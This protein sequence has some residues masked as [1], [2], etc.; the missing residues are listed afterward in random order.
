MNRADSSNIKQLHHPTP[1]P[2]HNTPPGLLMFN[3]R[4]RGKVGNLQ[5]SRDNF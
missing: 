2:Y 5:Y 1:L 3:H 4:A